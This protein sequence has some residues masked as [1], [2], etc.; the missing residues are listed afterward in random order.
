VASRVGEILALADAEAE[1][2]RADAARRAAE[3]AVECDRL[4][5]EAKDYAERLVE[6]ARRDTAQLLEQA[7][8]RLADA[9]RARAAIVESIALAHAQLTGSA[10]DT[11]RPRSRHA[12]ASDTATIELP[13]VATPA[14]HSTRSS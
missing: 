11:G 2:V 14:D 12:V 9:E 7:E 4:V 6:S 8:Q 13:H 10:T 5:S 1:A 3:A